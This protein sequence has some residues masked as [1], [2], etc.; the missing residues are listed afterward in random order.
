VNVQSA[1]ERTHAVY[2]LFQQLPGSTECVP[3]YQ[4]GAGF[5]DVTKTVRNL[6]RYG[7]EPDVV[8]IAR[9][10]V[11]ISRIYEGC[12]GDMTRGSRL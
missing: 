6:A 7:I 10:N 3:I 1:D 11:D 4:G 5:S 8:I 2:R 9:W 12:R